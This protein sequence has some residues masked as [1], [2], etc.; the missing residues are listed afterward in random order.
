MGVFNKPRRQWR[1]YQAVGGQRPV[2]KF[3]GGLPLADKAE[4]VAAMR[5]V[6]ED[7]LAVARHLRKDVYEVRAEGPHASY[8]VLF[9][10][11]GRWSQVLLALE[12]FSKKSQTTPQQLIDLAEARL[13]DWRERGKRP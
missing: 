4:I 9:S 8:R 3:I 1:D 13:H 12:A 5:Q 2:R 7:G 10:A 11:E 6:Q